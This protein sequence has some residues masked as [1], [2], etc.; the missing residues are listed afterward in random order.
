MTNQK[1][2]SETEISALS[3]L[4]NNG[5]V[6]ANALLPKTTTDPLGNIIPGKQVWLRLAR[7]GLV[8]IP[9]EDPITIHDEPFFCT[10]FI[11]LTDAGREAL[12]IS[13]S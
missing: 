4:H 9:E 13:Q 3:H 5:R 2:L 6:N 8:L 1:S 10:P 7:T 11:E 12:A